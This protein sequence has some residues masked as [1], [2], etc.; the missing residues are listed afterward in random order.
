MK[1]IKIGIITCHRVPNYGSFLQAWSLSHYLQEEGYKVEIIDYIYPNLYHFRKVY[2]K[3]DGGEKQIKSIKDKF[4]RYIVDRWYRASSK[5]GIEFFVY[6]FFAKYIFHNPTKN[7]FLELPLSRK[8]Y[9][10]NIQIKKA[11]NNY[12]ILIV[13]S[14]QIWNPRFSGYDSTFFLQFGGTNVKRIAYSAS[15]GVIKLPE[16]Y[17]DNYKKWL[18]TFSSIATREETG[19]KIVKELLGKPGIHVLD[20][21]MLFSAQQW[22][23]IIPQSNQNQP[24]ILSY[25]L[26]YIYKVY[27][28]VDKIFEDISLKLNL[29]KVSLYKSTLADCTIF[30]NLHP[31]EFVRFIKN[32]SFILVTS[33]HGLAYSILFH[34]P[35]LVIY[36]QE[37]INDSRIYDLLETFE[38]SNRIVKIGETVS[39]NQLEDI[40]WDK[41]DKIY[42]KI[43]NTSKKYLF[44]AINNKK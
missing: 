16:Q 12:D 22:E 4:H 38:L 5:R 34:V 1:K 25:C 43:L 39:N 29:H 41:V 13:G 32:A 35:F 36:P 10:N 40:D 28:F 9:H 31:F 8:T 6:S 21:V 11:A 33:F 42:N 30:N 17:K 27:P 20:P 2:N 44:E 7:F 37:P 14:D 23:A 24:Y 3:E 19:T 18:S 15:F 26:D